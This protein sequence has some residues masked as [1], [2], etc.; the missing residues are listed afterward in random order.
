MEPGLVLKHRRPD[1]VAM[2]A[3][4]G[5]GKRRQEDQDFQDHCRLYSAFKSS[6]GYIRIFLKKTK[7]KFKPVWTQ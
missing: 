5:F 3:T 7:N 1:G 4:P 6:P 2:H